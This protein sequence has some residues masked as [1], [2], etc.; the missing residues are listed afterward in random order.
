VAASKGPA[1]GSTSRGK[2]KKR[3]V[4]KSLHTVVT[5]SLRDMIIEGDLAPGQRISEGDLCEQFSISRTPMREALKVLA[6]EGLV[7]IR[8]NRG[9][10]VTEITLEEIDELFEAVSGIERIAGE[11]AAQ[12]MTERDLDRLRSL[13]IK[14]K[15]HFK[16]GNRHEYFILN[17]KAHNAIV[18]LANN[19]VLVSIHE[20][21][22]VKVR[23]AR[24]FAIL[25]VD[26][27][28]E[29]VREHENIIDAFAAR[30]ADLVGKL[31]MSHVRKTGT[32]VKKS[33]NADQNSSGKPRLY[34]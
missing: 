4:R 15:D 7:N 10:R 14:M 25:S 34:A 27:W 18:E 31:I 22:M 21:L 33:F 26:R 9:T 30:D 28:D 29:S 8:P 23:R 5:D 17:Q 2:P 24:Y 3:I 20:N 13:H 6:S 16:N 32:V 1:V 11:L 12:R 19:S